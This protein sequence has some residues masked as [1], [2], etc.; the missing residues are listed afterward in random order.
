MNS[1]AITENN[2]AGGGLLNGAQLLRTANEGLSEKV[3]LIR[4]DPE[5]QARQRKCEG[6]EENARDPGSGTGPWEGPL[7]QILAP[8]RQRGPFPPEGQHHQLGAGEPLPSLG[9]RPGERNLIIPV[10][11]DRRLWTSS[12]KCVRSRKRACPRGPLAVSVLT[13]FVPGPLC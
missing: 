13:A 3:R 8:R 9:K 10:S 7:W 4:P 2:G 6:Q 5:G 12:F 1:G 11:S